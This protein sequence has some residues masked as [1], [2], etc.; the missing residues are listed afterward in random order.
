MKFFIAKN[1]ILIILL[2]AFALLKCSS[3]AEDSGKKNINLSR[4]KR[5]VVTCADAKR[6]CNGNDTCRVV[7]K[8]IKRNCKVRFH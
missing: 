6:V 2:S 1:T 4:S 3:Y 7:L 8:R 5:S